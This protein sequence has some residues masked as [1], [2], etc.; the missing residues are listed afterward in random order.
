MPLKSEQFDHLDTRQRRA[1]M[2]RIV[3]G[4]VKIGGPLLV[5]GGPGTG[6]STT[7]AHCVT[8]LVNFGAD[9]GRFLIITA[10]PS[11]ARAMHKKIDKMLTVAGHNPAALGRP[12]IGTFH[13]VGH[14]VTRKHGSIGFERSGTMLSRNGT[15]SLMNSV[16]YSLQLISDFPSR[17]ACH[18]IYS[19]MVNSRQSLQEVIHGHFPQHTH[20]Y[21]NLQNVFSAYHDLKQ[22]RGVYEINDVLVSWSCLLEDHAT[23]DT[24]GGR[25]DYVLIDDFQLCT[26]LQLSIL[27]SLKPNGAGVTLFM[28]GTADGLTAGGTGEVFRDPAKTITL[29]LN[30]RSAASIVAAANGVMGR[31]SSS[32][33]P[34]AAAR[35]G[36]PRPRL[37]SVGDNEAEAKFIAD[38]IECNVA[39]G[40]EFKQHAALFAAL[41]DSEAL[42]REF[43]RR[44][45]PYDKLGGQRLDEAPAT[46]DC[47]A[48]LGWLERPTDRICGMRIL[49]RLSSANWR[50]QYKLLDGIA[51]SASQSGVR[52][53]WLPQHDV[54][55]V[56]RLITLMV[57]ARLGDLRWGARLEAAKR[58]YRDYLLKG[59]SGAASQ[60]KDVMQ[61]LRFANTFKSQRQFLAALALDPPWLKVSDSSRDRR[62]NAVTLSTFKNCDHVEWRS[63]YIL[64]VVGSR[65]PSTAAVT[66]DQIDQERRRFFVAMTRAKRDLVLLV[67]D[68]LSA[69]SPFLPNDVLSLFDKK[70][71][72]APHHSNPT[73]AAV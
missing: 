46:Q 17:E 12:T 5:Q 66:T 4:K 37:V 27:N 2:H 16:R 19:L 25:F 49:R 63:V 32:W 30:H 11:T 52:L 70:T 36:G 45:I 8:S 55:A 13:T 40:R 53:F 33:V 71:L 72:R 41:K 7:L 61:M 20:Q 48:L 43:D 6:K 57:K 3:N 56:D 65:M 14:G 69:R 24:I 35:S 26:R 42:E 34:L 10:S 18:E 73:F 51:G 50:E 31:S 28:D 1:V 22:D 21:F 44:Q 9:Y 47:L 62:D 15:L 68:G 60:A 29:R 64:N 38:D 39:N 58:W 23:A 59:R 67:P 54:A